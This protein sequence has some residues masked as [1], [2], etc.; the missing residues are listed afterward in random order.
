MPESFHSIG[1]ANST[2][3]FGEL[4]FIELTMTCTTENII[5]SALE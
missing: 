3:K 5:G 2:A 1:M 4:P